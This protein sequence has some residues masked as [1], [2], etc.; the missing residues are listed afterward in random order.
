MRDRSDRGREDNEVDRLSM[1]E[2]KK[3]ILR[4]KE[5]ERWTERERERARDT[6]RER[7]IE[8]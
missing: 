6:E 5:K 7:G 3:E 2:R 8:R 1:K 4:K